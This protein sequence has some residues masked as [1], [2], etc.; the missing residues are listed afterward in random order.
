MTDSIICTPADYAS[1]QRESQKINFSMPSDL[2]TGSLLRTLVA[3]KPAGRFLELG[4][5]TG[6]SLSWIVGAMDAK[7]SIISI[8]N[9]EEY[10]AIARSFFKD[11][12][13]VTILCTDGNQWLQQYQGDKFDLIF[14]DAWPGKYSNLDLALELL[15]PGGLYIID[16]MLPQ[17]NW[18]ENHQGNVDS[19]IAL[20]E[21]RTDVQLTKMNWSTGIIIVTKIG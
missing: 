19:L 15:V 7:S 5:G 1:I 17:P 6:L 3:S 21:A 9:S 20:L 4:T 14:A 18:P 13:R 11:N 12:S 10:L 2:Q 8:D 16:D